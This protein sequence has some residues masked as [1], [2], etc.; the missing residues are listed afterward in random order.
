MITRGLLLAFAIVMP[1]RGADGM[2]LDA[3]KVQQSVS[4]YYGDT[5][6]ESADLKTNACCT[7]ADMPKHIKTAL[8]KVHPEVLA[9]YY[10]CGL[11]IPD[12][13]DGLS[14]LDLGCGA[15]RDCYLLSQLV[16]EKG[17]VV[18]VDMTKAQ[19]DVAKE[20]AGWHANKFGYR[21]PNTEWIQPEDSTEALR[22][23]QVGQKRQTKSQQISQA[24]CPPKEPSL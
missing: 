24:F 16:G 23:P 21:G 22:G 6:K 5:L 20:H 17:R 2:V 13:L 8:S 1:K 3:L 9:K 10:G 12:E 15:G 19:I 14:V 18:G 11:T 7:G 4:T